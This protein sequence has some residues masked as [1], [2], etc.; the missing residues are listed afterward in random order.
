MALESILVSTLFL[1]S[2]TVPSQPLQSFAFH[3]IRDVLSRT[4]LCFGHDGGIA[5][6]ML[7]RGQRGLGVCSIDR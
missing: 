6:E 1:T 5:W 7:C 2:L 4:D 3:L